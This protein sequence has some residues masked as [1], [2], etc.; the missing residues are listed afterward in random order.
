MSEVPLYRKPRPNPGLA[1][2]NWFESTRER[3]TSQI[4]QFV[5]MA[6]TNNGSVQSRI[7]TDI[8]IR[9]LVDFPAKFIVRMA[10]RSTTR[11]LYVQ[12]FLANDNHTS[13]E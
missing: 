8:S 10:R 6:L 4:V 9:F 11:V 12:R 2:L 3:W 7:R 5:F 13:R 1:H